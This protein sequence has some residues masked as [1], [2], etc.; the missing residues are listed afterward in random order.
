MGSHTIS[1]ECS[2]FSC[3]Y[4]SPLVL[5]SSHP[6]C[7]CSR[8]R[9]IIV[10]HYITYGTQVA[11][12]GPAVGIAFGIGALCILIVIKN[13]WEHTKENNA[14]NQTTLTFVIAY[15]SFFVGEQVCEVS[16]VLACVVSGVVISGYGKSLL[17]EQHTLHNVWHVAEF[18]GN[19]IIFA[20]SGIIIGSDLYDEY[21]ED[22]NETG[23]Y[24][25]WMIV[26]YI[27]MILIR[28]G[29]FLI[30]Y[31]P[32]VKFG[33]GLENGWKDAFIG[34]WG[35]LRGAVGLIL[36]MIIDDDTTICNDGAPFVVLIGGA[37]FYTLC[38]N[39]FFS[40]VSMLVLH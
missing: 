21:E 12:G 37:T 9:A 26:V 15:L 31:F 23:K 25:G 22:E 8:L 3:R 2:S 4:A 36:C 10:S 29:T 28:A 32:L 13:G 35:G 19:T 7:I 16:G 27:F 30:L 6:Y 11:L 20:L 33:Y 34:V 39:G 17:T 18:M 24:F 14:S 40:L 1:Q 5:I 38:I